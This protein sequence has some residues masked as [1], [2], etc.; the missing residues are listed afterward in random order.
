MTDTPDI[1][2]PEEGKAEMV[3]LGTAMATDGK[4]R[5]LWIDA[6]V[7]EAMEP[8]AY[9]AAREAALWYPA[10]S[11]TKRTIGGRYELKAVFRGDR[12]SVWFGTARYIGQSA[13]PLIAAFQADDTRTR[14]AEYRA[15][16][17]RKAKE[18]VFMRDM[19][20]TLETLKAL[21]KRQALDIAD[22]IHIE[23]RRAILSGK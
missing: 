20:R 19:E 13:H 6:D 3:Y 8:T 7:F 10:K 17:E 16:N 18:P 14:D 22:A 23:L 12:R 9:N 15:K 2:S 21:P 5:A 4:A 11:D 1:L